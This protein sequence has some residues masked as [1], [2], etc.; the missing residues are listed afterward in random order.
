MTTKEISI[1]IGGMSQS[2]S[3]LLY[4]IVRLLLDMSSV[5]SSDCTHRIHKEHCREP[6]F[7]YY[8]VAVRDLRDVAVSWILKNPKMA[9]LSSDVSLEPGFVGNSD[10]PDCAQSLDMGEISLLVTK[11]IMWLENFEKHPERTAKNTFFWRYEGYKANP[12]K[13]TQALV[14]FLNLPRELYSL[15]ILEKI[16]NEAE[17]LIDKAPAKFEEMTPEEAAWNAKTKLLANNRTTNRGRTGHWE[18]FLPPRL[19]GILTILMAGFLMKY[20]YASALENK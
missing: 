3:T 10:A 19:I 13:S 16:I 20:G 8:L 12:I 18:E 4:N 7:D 6:H 11:N 1:Q 5:H 14:T 17:G 15:Q 9:I 2:G